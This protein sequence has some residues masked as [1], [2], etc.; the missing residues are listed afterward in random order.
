MVTFT[1]NRAKLVQ[2]LKQVNAAIG[3]TNAKKLATTGELTVID[4]KV[5]FAIPGAIFTLECITQGTCKATFLFV[6]FSQIITDSKPTETEV[7]ITDGKIK[8]NSVTISAKTTFFETDRILRTIH[9][10]MNYTDADLLRLTTQGYTWEELDF[11][12]LIPSITIAEE[13]LKTNINQ[14]FRCLKQYGITHEMLVQMVNTKL[15]TKS[16]SEV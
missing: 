5:T 2:T 10:P 3:K 8:I 13:K 14:A 12:K 7:I 15:H 16:K 4:G 6:H 1:A 9:L 11:N